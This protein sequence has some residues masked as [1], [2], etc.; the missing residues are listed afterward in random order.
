[1]MQRMSRA[2]VK[3]VED[4]KPLPPCIL[5]PRATA[6]LTRANALFGTQDDR[7]GR[8]CRANDSGEVNEMNRKDSSREKET[9]KFELQQGH[10][11]SVARDELLKRA[12]RNHPQRDEPR[13]DSVE[14]DETP[15]S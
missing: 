5:A 4:R 2:R 3:S 8:A 14:P 15:T 7:R 1:M 12:I 13:V 11:R 9:A 6:G 10:G